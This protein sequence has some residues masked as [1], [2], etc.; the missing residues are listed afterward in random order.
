MRS[1]VAAAVIVAALHASAWFVAHETTAPPDTETTL[2]SLSYSPYG[3]TQDPHNG[4]V[5]TVEQ[6]DRDL[7][8]VSQVARAVRTYSTINGFETIPALARKHG[9]NVT[10][11]AWVDKDED[12]NR[13]EIDAAIELARTN[14]NVKS[15]LVGNE[16]MYRADKT[17]DE[18]IT[19]L[20]QVRKRVKV[21][22]STGEIWNIWLENPRLVNEVDYIAVHILPY[23]EGVP[24]E[25]TLTYTLSRLDDLR[26]KYPGKKIVIGEYGWPSNGYNKLAA[27]PGPMIQAKLLREFLAEARKRGID[28]NV[29]EAIDQPWKTNEGSVGAY[30]GMFDADRTL[31]FPLAGSFETQGDRYL[32]A[33]AL[34]LGLVLTVVGL[35]RRRPTFGHAFAYSAAANALGTGLVMAAAYPFRNYMNGGIWTMWGIGIVMLTPLVAISLAKVHEIADVLLG[36]RPQRLWRRGSGGAAAAGWLPKVSIHIPAY[37]EQPD[38]LKATLDSVAA[39]DYPNFEAVVIINNT[40]EEHYWK[41]IQEHCERLGERFRFLNL[42]KVAGFKAGAMNEALNHTAA[43]AEIIA[44][45]D[46]DYMV[47]RDWLKDLVPAFADPR[48]GMVQ[49]PQDHRDGGES[50]LKRMM[51]W[52]Y[53]GFFDIGM[54]QR[55]E[56][57]AIVA[58]GTMLMV[59]RSAFEEVGG[60][61]TD[62]IVEDSELGLRLFEAGYTAHYTNTRYGWGVLPDTFKAFKTQRHRWAYGAVQIF[63]KHWQHMT[64]GSRTLTPAQKTQYLTGWFYWLSDALG[65]GISFLNLFWVPVI[66]TIGLAI[67]TSMTLPIVV[68]FGINLLHSMLLYRARVKASLPD[69]LG[70]AI[71]AMSLQLTVARAVFDGFVKDG[72]PFMRTEKGGNTKKKNKGDHS[73]RTETI[74]GLALLGAAIL[75]HVQN[76]FA[77]LEVDVFAA[78]LA[79]QSLPFLSATVMRSI[80][81]VQVWHRNRIPAPSSS[82]IAAIP[83]DGGLQGA[84]G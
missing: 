68:A 36:H 27:V 20:R 15:V 59:R 77:H 9:L 78:T 43:D 46:A 44:V 70:A 67:P 80:E 1:V 73:A 61:A 50:L 26:R 8:L 71:A 39:L 16:T 49:A 22:V 38:M 52:E 42:V 35:R 13:R 37:R 69:T 33:A 48:V 64:P 53:D 28:Y 83:A 74:L 21:P 11:G 51:K 55:N 56:D 60:W 2:Q 30:W 79:I 5:P 34:A 4:D 41:P 62:T 17:V 66:L 75:V 24:A 10:L 18:M 23:W 12:R 57:N 54:V 14:R 3:K 58:H 32:A 29:V 63:K 45:I 7:G 82:S 72:L 40:P 47:G 81:K 6:I 84:A 65:A 19:L 25:H 31:K 76:I